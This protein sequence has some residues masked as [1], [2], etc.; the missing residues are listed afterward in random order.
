MLEAR[1]GQALERSRLLDEVPGGRETIVL[2][3][4]A[5]VDHVRP[6]TQELAGQ[7]KAWTCRGD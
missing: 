4:A 5:L 1:M 3:A 2:Q 6:F 7:S